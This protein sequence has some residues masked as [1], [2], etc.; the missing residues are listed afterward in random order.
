MERAAAAPCP[1]CNQ[2]WG[3]D[4]LAATSLLNSIQVATDLTIPLPQRGCLC[5]DCRNAGVGPDIADEQ[6]NPYEVI[7]PTDAPRPHAEVYCQYHPDRPMQWHVNRSQMGWT[8]YWECAHCDWSITAQN[9]PTS[10]GASPTCNYYSHTECE[11]LVL[12]SR[13]SVVTTD[14]DVVASLLLNQI[15][16]IERHGGDVCHRKIR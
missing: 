6:L 1:L 15:S 16:S 14:V 3:D 5:I 4:A 11:W 7:Q 8:G 9:I 12:V 10:T 2:I 13:N